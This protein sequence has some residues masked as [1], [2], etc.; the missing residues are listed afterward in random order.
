MTTGRVTASVTNEIN[1][2]NSTNIER[3]GRCCVD[4]SFCIALYQLERKSVRG[5]I[6]RDLHR[7]AFVL[8]GYHPT[9]RTQLSTF[10]SGSAPG[11]WLVNVFSTRGREKALAAAYVPGG[12]LRSDPSWRLY[13][14][15]TQFR[16]SWQ[17]MSR[18]PNRRNARGTHRPCP[19]LLLSV[20][21]ATKLAEIATYRLRR[22]SSSRS[23]HPPPTER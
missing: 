12:Q 21:N 7:G 3:E 17:S 18:R 19:Y 11:T 22:L 15:R 4:D 23:S 13:G 6:Q 10:A 1:G 8:A 2:A 16:S 9:G 14:A 20:S 5:K